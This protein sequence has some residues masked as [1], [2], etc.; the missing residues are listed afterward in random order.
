MEIAQTFKDLSALIDV[1]QANPDRTRHR[2]PG[3]FALEI[4]EDQ[5]VAKG[6]YSDFSY[7][8]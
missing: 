8:G 3:T 6:K 7:L 5:R 4:K 2:Y 1:F